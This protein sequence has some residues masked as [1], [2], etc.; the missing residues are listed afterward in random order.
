ML[1]K[2]LMTLL[3]AGPISLASAETIRVNPDH[4]D[5]Y[6][7]QKGDT[8]WDISARFLEQPWRWPEIWQVNPEIEN[9]HLIYPGDIVRLRFDGDTPVLTVDRGRSAGRQSATART[10]RLSPQI[11][12]V[13]REEAIHS[14]PIDAIG[15]FLTRPLVVGEHEMNDWPYI[16]SS[17]EQRLIAGPGDDIYI[18]GLDRADRGTGYSIYRKGPE[19]RSRTS[20]KEVSLG[21]EAIYVGEAEIRQGGNPAIGRVSHAVREVLI[22]DRLTPQPEDEVQSD[23]IPSMP[24][25][26]IRGSIISARDVLS[27]IGQYRIVT[28]DKGRADGL[29]TGDVLGVYQT[30]RTVTDR[31][32]AESGN[33]IINSSLVEYLGKPK[34]GGEQV[35]LPEVHAAVILVFRVFDRVSYALVME[36]YR[37]VHLHDVVRNL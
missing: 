28:V 27:E 3:L 34:A 24:D 35:E 30:G 23:F 25:G 11:R 22:G 20:G 31:L 10:V 37:P 29:E 1:H 16:V 26:T 36:A 21:Y 2:V 7:V 33:R 9:P 17:E 6:V 18:R 12:S 15:Q 4:P 19:Y 14:I 13:E 5:E 8:L 32:A